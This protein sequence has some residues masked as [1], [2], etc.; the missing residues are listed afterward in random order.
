MSV[1]AWLDPKT[2]PRER[3]PL[4]AMAAETRELHEAIDAHARRSGRLYLHPSDPTL[5]LDLLGSPEVIAW[6][7]G[8]A[9]LLFEGGGCW[10]ELPALYGR[11]G[12]EAGRALIGRIRELEAARCA[13]VCDSGMQAAAIVFDVLLEPGSHAVVHRQ[14]YN[15]SSRYLSW[16]CE[17]VGAELTVVDD[18][19]RDALRRAIQPRTTLV[20]AETYTNP[21]LRALDLEEVPAIVAEARSRAP[22]LRLVVDSTIATPWGVR[23]PLL[24]C[25]VDVVVTSGTKS[26]G[27]QDRDLSGYIATND[28]D[29]ANAAMDLLAMRGG[30]LDW[31]RAEAILQGLDAAGERHQR[32]CVSAARMAAF[33]AE[34]PRVGEVF[35]PSL[36]DHPDARAIAAGYARPGSLLSFRLR[37]GDEE[38]ARHVSDVLA[39]TM[40]VRYALSFDGLVTKVNHHKSVSEYFT[41]PEATKRQGIDELIRIAI[42]VE[43]CNDLIAAV[44]WALHHAE[45]V[46]GGDLARWR[47]ERMASLGLES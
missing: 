16:L 5:Q 25:G 19:D 3:P 35:H 26:L 40:V 11:Y 36:A 29:L 46:S 22:G 6:Q 38:A 47:E 1:E 45:S 9:A 42:G 43:D 7:E 18:G 30:I 44:N 10:S 41:A 23:R 27:G 28:P 17:R 8:K 12:T 20:F 21:L 24:G 31:R 37:D 39:T 14:V 32:R 2:C 13:L 15:K 34:H 33:L 4:A